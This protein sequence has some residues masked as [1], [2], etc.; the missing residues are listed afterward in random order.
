MIMFFPH[1]G[2]LPVLKI[3]V[4]P[5]ISSDTFRSI[6]KNS[7]KSNTIR[8]KKKKVSSWTS[9]SVRSSHQGV[10]CGAWALGADGT[11]SCR[12]CIWLYE[13][14]GSRSCSS[15]PS[16]QSDG[17]WLNQETSSK[18]KTVSSKIGRLGLPS[19]I[20]TATQILVAANLLWIWKDKFT[21]KF[22]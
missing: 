2:K 18:R 20:P 8:K 15:T 10:L 9:V 1:A 21:F 3:T 13:N 19:L 12:F 17:W 16:F 4:T 5:Q 11:I 22:T 14:L 6:W 7:K